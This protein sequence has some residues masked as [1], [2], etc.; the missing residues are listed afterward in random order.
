[1]EALAVMTD[2]ERRLRAAMQ[3]AVADKQPPGN[4][5]Q[6]V[7]RRHRRHTA[8]IAMAG[9]AAVAVVA[10]LVPVGIGAVGHAPGPAGRHRPPTAPTV[11]VAYPNRN[12]SK[13]GAIIPISIAGIATY[14]LAGEVRYGTALALA[15]GSVVGAPL[16]ARLLAQMDERLLKVVFGVFLVGVAVLMGVR[17]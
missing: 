5:V 15:V 6:Q 7:Q 10:V 1:M 2:F 14:G 13:L 11:Y 8:R 17:G 9:T 4:L 12:P 16:G 3:S